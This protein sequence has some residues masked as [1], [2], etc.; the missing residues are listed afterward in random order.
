MN[1]GKKTKPFVLTKDNAYEFTV[2]M[3]M[4]LEE[5]DVPTEEIKMPEWSGEMIDNLFYNTAVVMAHRNDGFSDN[6]GYYPH[7][8]RELNISGY[9]IKTVFKKLREAG[10]DLKGRIC[11]VHVPEDCGFR[12][13]QAIT[14]QDL[15]LKDFKWNWDPEWRRKKKILMRRYK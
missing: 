1:L 2:N 8:V 5:H 9:D 3:G 4:V 6:I 15:L 7:G 13:Y 12:F 14:L 10:F 11:R